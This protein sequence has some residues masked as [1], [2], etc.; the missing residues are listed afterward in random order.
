MIDDDRESLDGLTFR[1]PPSML[2]CEVPE[3]I[4]GRVSEMRY[5]MAGFLGAWAAITVASVAAQTSL[6]APP[7]GH[8]KVTV[9]F[10]QATQSG[11]TGI[12]AQGSRPGG[13][14]IQVDPRGVTGSARIQLQEAQR[15]VR[16]SVGS[17]LLG[18]ER[19]NRTGQVSIVLTGETP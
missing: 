1:G 9:E 5:I 8:V 15:T 6:I 11:E 4:L 17:F 14:I 10:R 19:V 16:R 3:S 13:T 18:Y 2:P 12:S 7:P